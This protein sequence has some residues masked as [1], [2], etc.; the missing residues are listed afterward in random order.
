MKRLTAPRS[1]AI[2][3]GYVS[4]E[5]L[6]SFVISFLF[7]VA[8]FF[9]NQILY[10]ARDRLSQSVS[11]FDTMRLIF[12][13]LPAIVALS[14]PFGSL[15]GI[16]MTAGKLSADREIMAM[17]AS[18]VGL[19]WL[20]IPLMVLGLGLSGISF[21]VND[22]L[23]PLGTLRYT[24]L[25]Q[26]LLFANSELALSPYSVN[27]YER[28][29]I[30]TGEVRD[31]RF[32]NTLLMDTT[33]D[34]RDRIINAGSGQIVRNARQDGVISLELNQVHI[35]ERDPRRPEHFSTLDA[36]SMTYSILLREINA[37][38]RNPGP[39]EMSILDLWDLIQQREQTLIERGFGVGPMVDRTLQIYWI[40]F[41]KKIAIPL[42]SLTFV[43]LGFPIALGARH[44][45]RAVG[46]G[47]GVLFS[48]VYWG[49]LLG[50]ETLGVRF[51]TIPPALIILFPNLIMVVIGLGIYRMRIHR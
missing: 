47:L 34:G 28:T 51:L 31:G 25:Y 4:R 9:V 12:Y 27:Q 22:Y 19:H 26:E 13:A 11:F 50:A 49:M 45:G 48:V 43:I 37:A 18:G 33:E 5:Y 30:V 8:I 1:P 20:F 17:R 6:F 32:Y 35:L 39:R 7:F 38:L 44:N 40:E 21:G 46:F 36:D 42:A 16:L 41:W 23:L 15:L 24:T 14:F 10:L 29:T 3:I 2:L